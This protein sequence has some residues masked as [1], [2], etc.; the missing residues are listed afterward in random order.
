MMLASSVEGVLES[1]HGPLARQKP[2][3][4][5]AQTAIM[6]GRRHSGHHP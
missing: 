3:L 4:R 2:R 6:S 1:H 5:D